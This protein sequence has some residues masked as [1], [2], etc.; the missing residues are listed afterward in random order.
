MDRALALALQEDVDL[1]ITRLPAAL[2]PCDLIVAQGP[3]GLN[4]C[5]ESAVSVIDYAFSK[6]I[7]TGASAR[8]YEA[9]YRAAEKIIGHLVLLPEDARTETT[10]KRETLLTQIDQRLALTP[11]TSRARYLEVRKT[12][13]ER[14]DVASRE[15][16]AP[17]LTSKGGSAPADPLERE[18]LE[19]LLAD[20]L[21]VPAAKLD[22][23]AS[24]IAHPGLRRLLDGLYTLYHEGLTPDLDGL[25]LRI[26]DNAP[27]ADFA[28]RF[29]EVGLTHGDRPGWL[30]QILERFRERRL[31]RQAKEVRGKLN[32]TTDHDA[33]VEQLKKL[34]QTTAAGPP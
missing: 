16:E 7:P 23:A 2:D 9:N 11:G 22:V 12:A 1:A 6:E 30:R 18:L 14:S 31:A 20:P 21:L 25:R 27:L 28:L 5:L 17:E 24:E 33:A 8:S 32:A 4:G 10:I 19:V 34:Q 3:E 15:R 29:Q 13:R 26:A